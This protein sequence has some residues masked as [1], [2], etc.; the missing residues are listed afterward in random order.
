MAIIGALA[1]GLAK[2]GGRA[3]ASNIMGRKKTVKPSAIAPRQGAQG[4]QQG[5][6]KGSAL[7]KSPTTAITKAMAP[8]QK[9]STGPVAKG[10]YLA[11]IH[12]KVLTI[13]KIVTGVYKAE[14]DNLKAEKQAEKDDDRKNKEQ[15]LETKDKKP[16]KKKPSLKQLPKLGV[17]GWLKRFIGNILMGLFLSKMVDFA[18]LLPKIV[19]TIDS[20]TTFL[21]DFGILMVNAL[22]TFA[23]WGIKAYN[24]TFGAIEKVSGTLFGENADKVVGLIDTALFLTT[25]IAASMAVESLMGDD[26]GDFSSKKPGRRGSP[27]VTQGR[28]GRGPRP[29]IPGTGPRVTGGG[30]GLKIPKFPRL[31]FG[32]VVRGLAGPFINTLLAIW[33]FSSRKSAGQT[34]VQAGAGTGGGILGG[35][36]G[37]ALAAT[38]FPEPFSSAAGLITLGILGSLGYAFGGAG[39][40]KLTG[41]DKVG[42]YQEGGRV[43]RKKVRRGIDIRKKKRKKIRLARPTREI[44]APLPTVDEKKLDPDDVGKNNREWWDFLGWAGTGN[45]EKPLGQGGKILAEKTTKVG[46]ELGKND[47]F[48]PILR[49]ASKLILDQDITSRDYSNIGRGINLLVDDGIVKNKVGTLG[50]NQGGLAENLPQ[51][52]VTDW[53][54]KTF[55]DTLRD[56][57]KKKYLPN[58]SYGSTSGPGSTPGSRDSVTGE[59]VPGSSS[60]ARHGSPE[61]KA[62]LDVLAYAEGTLTNRNGATGPAGYS[63]WAGYQMHGPSDLTGLTIQ[64]VHDLQTSFM[65]AGKTAMTGSAV[66]GRYQFKD[67]LEHY[68][69]QAGLSGGDL[70]SP[71]NQ[72]KMA[73]EEI[74]KR[75]GITTEM[76]KNQGVTQGYLDKLAPIWASMPYSP[77]GGGSYYGGQP[78]KPAGELKDF[79]KQRLGIQISEQQARADIIEP[80]L[81]ET[82]EMQAGSSGYTVTRSGQTIT[83]FSQLPAHHTYQRSKDGRGALVQD[84]TLYKN[85]KFFG[86]PVPSPVSGKVSWAGSA[87]GGGN[88]VELMSDSGQKVEL[89]HFDKIGVKAGQT[90]KAFSTSL[91]TQGFTGNIRP[92]NKDGTHVHM[93]APDEVMKRYVNTLA[94]YQYGGLVRGPGGIDN[95]PAMLTAGEIII[96]VDSAGPARNLLLAMNQAS[97]KAG[98]IKAIRD[99]APYDARAE[100]TIMVP[101]VSEDVPQVLPSGGSSST[102]LLPILMGSSN[103]FEF[104]EYQG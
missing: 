48:G 42:Q 1:K 12:E 83:N 37:A 45:A 99:Y 102:T 89:G 98:I 73:I 17:F 60:G 93:Q 3:V 35:I 56:D 10:D 29:R 23:D 50:Y 18:G 87:G 7:V 81:P 97:D 66:V 21:A 43:R 100:Q 104:L 84:F 27:G 11:I 71:E 49:V 15:R 36:A 79:Y 51:L 67:L 47:Y 92:K 85:K 14:K 55:E 96:D 44:M 22:T 91:G 90:V 41:A 32:G 30:G 54:S 13:E 65:K 94:K 46:N 74:R 34:N 16:E 39:A 59:M 6:R 38:L 86:I 53:V 95:V 19:R 70:F 88:W 62:L 80:G 72:D 26:G 103:P 8:I 69:P 5:Q 40:D 58:S 78:S 52:D 57:L 9:V 4:Q 76:L 61:M 33:D 24:F 68:A 82:P 20:V 77:K 31:P 2:G 64:E 75:A 28:G 101:E 63:T 25:A